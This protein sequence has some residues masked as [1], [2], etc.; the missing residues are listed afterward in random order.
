MSVFFKE[1]T[2][3]VNGRGGGGGGAGVVKQGKLGIGKQSRRR[4]IC[5][6]WL[7]CGQQLGKFMH[8]Q[9]ASDSRLFFLGNCCIASWKL[10]I[11]AH[12]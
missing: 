9:D 8:Q 4:S 1:L 11:E 12:G 7:S 10:Y 5:C 2:L 6:F 3:A